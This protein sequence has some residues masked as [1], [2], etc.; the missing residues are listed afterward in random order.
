MFIVR[1]IEN[2]ICFSC[3]LPVRMR[4]RRVGYLLNAV[5]FHFEFFSSSC[6]LN[7]THWCGENISVWVLRPSH[8][9][10]VSRSCLH[11]YLFQSYHSVAW[12]RKLLFRS[13]FHLTLRLGSVIL[14]R[15]GGSVEREGCC[16]LPV[17]LP[18]TTHRIQPRPPIV[19]Y[20][21]F[22]FLPCDPYRYCSALLAGLLTRHGTCTPPGEW[23]KGVSPHSP[24]IQHLLFTVKS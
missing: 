15:F 19:V 7:R 23:Y 4:Q 21:S 5:W 18:E 2:F 20:S 1:I 22:L 14:K 13:V 9:C 12:V 24:G 17:P 11:S 10:T 3:I 16:I 6:S 8:C